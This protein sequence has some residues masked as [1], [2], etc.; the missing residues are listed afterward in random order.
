MP[1]HER[2]ASYGEKGDELALQIFAQQAAAIGRMF[3]IASNY[4]D[5]DAYFVGGG[6]VESAP[7]FRDWFLEGVRTATSLREEQRAVARFA[8]VVRPRHGR[9]TGIGARC[10]ARHPP[11]ARPSH[12]TRVS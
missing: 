11:R 5:P 7:H 9:C 8:V 4:T 10:P 2:C 1:R 3:T 6:V 12:L